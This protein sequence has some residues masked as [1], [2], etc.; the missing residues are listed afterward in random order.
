MDFLDTNVLIY[1]YDS[2]APSEKISIAQQCIRDAVDGHA[3][4]STQ[5][6]NELASVLTTKRR[7]PTRLVRQI[8]DVIAPVPVIGTD[9][10]VVRRALDACDRYGVHFY[11]GLVIA[12]AERAGAGRLLTEDLN[13]GQEYFGV[14]VYNPF[15]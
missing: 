1:A 2:V 7:L 14:T 9:A 3:C 13:H 11:D 4:T 15:Q 8:L 10:S 12:A 6:L 5:V